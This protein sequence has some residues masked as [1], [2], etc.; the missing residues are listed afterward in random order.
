MLK[1]S[2]SVLP[3]IQSSELKYNFL[4]SCLF[5]KIKRIVDRI[6][7]SYHSSGHSI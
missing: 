5:T 4:K 1:K 7:V 6:F 2:F 3:Y